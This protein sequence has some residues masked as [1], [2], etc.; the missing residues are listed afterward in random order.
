MVKSVFQSEVDWSPAL[1]QR[2]APKPALKTH[3]PP[4]RHEQKSGPVLGVVAD[5]A[6]ILGYHPPRL[7]RTECLQHTLVVAKMQREKNALARSLPGCRE[8]A[9]QQLNPPAVVPNCPSN[10]N[11]DQL[12]LFLASL[13]LEIAAKQRP[14]HVPL[15]A[16]P[17][18][19]PVLCIL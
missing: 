12:E 14:N 15:P 7:Q 11:P 8:L 18:V 9:L 19:P 4:T 3:G 1:G 13:L 17:L 16:L 10:L 5:V 2:P 6:V